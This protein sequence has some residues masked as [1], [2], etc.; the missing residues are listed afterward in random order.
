MHGYRRY[1]L[2]NVSVFRTDNRSSYNALALHLQGNVAERLNLVANYTLASARTWGCQ[3]GELF[4]YLNG[5]CDPFN[6]FAQADYS[7]Y[8]ADD[9]HRALVSGIRCVY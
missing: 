4:D 1:D 6:A 3:I 2:R 5:A 7:R 8:R 9:R